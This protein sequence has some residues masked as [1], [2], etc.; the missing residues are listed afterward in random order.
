MQ[1]SISIP[2]ALTSDKSKES[3]KT[4][5][6][7]DCG[8]GGQFIDQNYVR[9]FTIQKPDEPLMAY[10]VDGTEHKRGKITS[11]VDLTMTING[12]MMDTWLLV[13]GLGKQKVILGFPWLAQ[14]NPDIIA[15]CTKDGTRVNFNKMCPF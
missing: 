4:T 6:L 5:A 12:Q 15:V 11:F 8:A 9:K 1:N 14:E 13:T 7:I 3:V 10:N 2:I